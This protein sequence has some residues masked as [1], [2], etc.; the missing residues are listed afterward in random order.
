MM[1][2]AYY[3]TVCVTYFMA[4]YINLPAEDGPLKPVLFS[5]VVSFCGKK[6]AGKLHGSRRG[7]GGVR[8]KG[9]GGGAWR[10]Y[11]LHQRRCSRDRCSLFY[12]IFNA[13]RPWPTHSN[14]LI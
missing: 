8:R 10:E 5:R 11:V 12:F 2:I 1:T 9:L 14:P 3:S 13:K 7:G 6:V 4:N